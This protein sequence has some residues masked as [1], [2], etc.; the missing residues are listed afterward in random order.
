MEK[1]ISRK[2][3]SVGGYI[4]V[5]SAKQVREG[6][7]LDD[8]KRSIERYTQAHDYHLYRIYSDEGISGA[9]IDRPAL[10]EMK[11]DAE[12]GLFNRVAFTALDRL[13]RD[14]IDT[15]ANYRFFEEKGIPLYSIKEGI[16]TST[17][18]GRLTRTILAAIAE[19]E[20]ERIRDRVIVGLIGRAND[21]KPIGKTTFGYRWDKE[22]KAYIIEPGEARIYKMIVDLFLNKNRSLLATAKTLN[23]KG[24]RT[25]YKKKW[26]Q[27]SLGKVLRNPFY[28]GTHKYV[29]QGAE[30][31]LPTPRLIDR[32]QWELIQKRIKENI[33]KSRN[34]DPDTPWILRGLLQCKECGF[35]FT[36]IV[37]GHDKEG[38]PYRF[39]KCY[40][41][42]LRPSM[43]A[44]KNLEKPVICL[45]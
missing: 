36:P 34:F 41:N 23:E 35:G 8:Q 29:C 6:E 27:T 32:G 5:S 24:Y 44:A 25:R 37:M 15:L 9:K 16:D 13:G 4:R 14:A 2:R 43:R 7:S 11:R 10:V 45:L 30:Y 40:V 39:Y 17:S 3:I 19:M 20:R 38:N 33:R 28:L 22:K 18:V 12:K 31:E 21:G 1:E 42:N 26:T